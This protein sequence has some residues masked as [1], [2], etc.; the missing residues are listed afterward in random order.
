MLEHFNSGLFNP[1]LQPRTFWLQRVEIFMGE[2]SRVEKSYILL[3]SGQ[4]NTQLLNFEVFM[5]EKSRVEKSRV[6]K[7]RVEKFGLKYLG[8]KYS[9]TFSKRWLC[10]GQQKCCVIVDVDNKI[11]YIF[12]YEEARLFPFLQMKILPLLNSIL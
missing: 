5:V 6:E 1:K 3:G 7:S 11:D 12:S 9:A 4:L 8:L 10:R 2:K